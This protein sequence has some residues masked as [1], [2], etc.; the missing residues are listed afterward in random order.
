MLKY[1]RELFPNT[2]VVFCGVENFN[3]KELDTYLKQYV[4]G[5]V[6][7]KDIRKNLELIYQLFPAIK[8]VYIISDDAYSSLVIKDQIIEESN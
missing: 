1:H 6:E 5:V 2:P 8:M 4:T 7:Y 3:P